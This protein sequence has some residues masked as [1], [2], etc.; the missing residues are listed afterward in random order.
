MPELSR[1]RHSR[2]TPMSGDLEAQAVAALCYRPMPW[3][4]HPLQ[5]AVR[6]L[7]ELGV[8]VG[9]VLAAL[10]LVG[11]PWRLVLAV[12]APLAAATAWGLFNVAGDPSRS[13]RAPIPVSGRVRL[14]LEAIYFALGVLAFIAAGRPAIGGGLAA[15]TAL[16]YALSLD[17]IR[18]LLAR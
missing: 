2:L 18:W 4:T 15:T 8:L 9:L 16:H 1:P 11:A 3:A 7:L 10:A 5:L 17:R 6:F 12:A 14:A 13:G